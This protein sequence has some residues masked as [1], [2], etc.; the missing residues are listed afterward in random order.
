MGGDL[1]VTLG[2]MMVGDLVRN[3]GGKI[4]SPKKIFGRKNF[5]LIFFEKK[6]FWGKK[7]LGG[8]IVVRVRVRVVRIEVFFVGLLR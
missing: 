6:F 4:F 8:K 2:E 1:G 7:I 3:L 5:L